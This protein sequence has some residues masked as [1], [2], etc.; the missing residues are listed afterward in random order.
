MDP[1]LKYLFNDVK[2]I[3]LLQFLYYCNIIL[4]KTHAKV[5]LKE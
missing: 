1:T 2:M 3:G 4:Q 5:I